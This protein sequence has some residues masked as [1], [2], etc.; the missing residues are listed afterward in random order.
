MEKNEKQEDKEANEA[1]KI[2]HFRTQLKQFTDFYSIWKKRIAF[3]LK[4]FL[5]QEGFSNFNNGLEKAKAI[6]DSFLEI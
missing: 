4:L 6:L 2:A 1:R 5:T 3:Y